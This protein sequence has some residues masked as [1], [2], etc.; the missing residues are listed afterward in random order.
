MPYHPFSYQFAAQCLYNSINRTE[1]ETLDNSDVPKA[2]AVLL[3][4][5][6]MN[7]RQYDEQLLEEQ[8]LSGYFTMPLTNEELVIPQ[9]FQLAVDKAIQAT[10]GRGLIASSDP[11]LLRLIDLAAKN[12]A[13]FGQHPPAQ[14]LK[15]T[16]GSALSELLTCPK[17][18]DQA[19]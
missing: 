11:D 9:D 15:S 1:H 4:F 17:S 8:G 16:I 12:G 19:G 6:R 3:M 5:L 18:W 13:S 7:S 14:L 10:P 2:V